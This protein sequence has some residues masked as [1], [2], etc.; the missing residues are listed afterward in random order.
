VVAGELRCRV[1]APAVDGAANE[2]LVRLL[3]RELGV[4]PSVVRI[5]SGLSSRRKIVAVPAEAAATA[6]RRW[7]DLG[8]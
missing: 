2:A 3:A 8:R 1:A 6:A 7:P 5:V 4:P